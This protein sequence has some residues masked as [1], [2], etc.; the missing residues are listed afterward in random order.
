MEVSV[1]L[2]SLTA[3]TQGKRKYKSDLEFGIRD[4][5][6]S[7]LKY[8]GTNSLGMRTLNYMEV[9]DILCSLG[10]VYAVFWAVTPCSLVE[11][12]RCL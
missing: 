12:Y 4:V 6:E 8:V 7:M 11:V 1:Q 9:V 5:H 3:L 2:H 10:D